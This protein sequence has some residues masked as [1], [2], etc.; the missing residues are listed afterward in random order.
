M[1][2]DSDRLRAAYAARRQAQPGRDPIA[3][4]AGLLADGPAPPYFFLAIAEDAC[5][6]GRITPLVDLALTRQVPL[7]RPAPR[8]GW[9]NS[10]LLPFLILSG[11]EAGLRTA[12]SHLEAA[13]AG[14][15]NTPLLAWL[16][17]H[18][19]HHRADLP[20]APDLLA[21]WL[22]ILEAEA[23]D[24]WGRAP[25]RALL[26]ASLR[27]LDTPLPEPLAAEVAAVCLR[28][29]GLSPAFWAALA[30]R[31]LPPPLE[32]GRAAFAA[33][34]AAA[35]DPGTP[36]G[37]AR[38]ALDALRAQGVHGIEAFRRECPALAQP[39]PD[40]DEARLRQA[41]GPPPLGPRRWPRF[42][43]WSPH[44]PAPAGLR[45]W[46]ATLA[47]REDPA[48]RDLALIAGG[49]HLDA[50]RRTAVAV[51]TVLRNER[52]MLPH[53]L[54]HYRRL[55]VGAFLIADNGSDD[56]SAEFLAAQPD[57]V[58]FSAKAP[59]REAMQ[60]TEWKIALMAQLRPGRWSLVADA[61]E[62]L[63]GA[64]L[65]Q[66]GGAWR[67]WGSLPALVARAERQGYDAFRIRML[68]VYP[69][70]L[71]AEARLDRAEP[72]ALAPLADR[73]AFVTPALDL[74]PFSDRRAV[75][76][77]L[78]HRL[79]PGSA[80]ELFV[81]EKVPLL[82]YRP[83]MRLSVS[84]HY[85]AE[86]RIAPQELV[87]AHVKYTS[88]FHARVQREIGRGQYFN[89]AAEYRK[90]AELLAEGRDRIAEPGVSV[91]WREAVA[92]LL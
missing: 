38:A 53:F 59:F 19:A 33:L 84:L 75:R 67:P 4:A 77:G 69:A 54:A 88:D 18:L 36:A 35:L 2:G 10:A 37:P 39:G 56:G 61:D 5:R 25:C 57:V 28:V 45:L 70:G 29:Y 32:E 22:H 90:Y 48:A 64:G 23:R 92:G 11:D 81:S 66:P 63:A 80:P 82:R 86:V 40:E 47:A 1:A 72:L 79:I 15:L 9:R 87:F 49:A 6:A 62:L 7:P 44:A 3:I 89:N 60:G 31:A 43:P 42:W 68:D 50:A 41:A 12:L 34:S 51:V 85:A 13:R 65:R 17:G 30:G 71:L 55:G 8:D 20:A 27:L 83:W 58:L 46:P 76:S 52:P 24:P 91:P 14:W 21:Q 73:A 16:A 26:A 78:R 74:G